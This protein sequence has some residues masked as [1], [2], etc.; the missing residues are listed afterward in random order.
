MTNKDLLPGSTI[1]E[2]WNHFS[3]I[4]GKYSDGYKIAPDEQCRKYGDLCIG[5][6]SGIDIPYNGKIL[7]IYPS[8]YVTLTILDSATYTNKG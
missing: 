1:I 4:T 6:S 7:R 8:E 5:P 2:F 3:R